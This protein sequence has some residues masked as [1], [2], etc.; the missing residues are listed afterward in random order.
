MAL[1]IL[2]PVVFDLR[3]NLTGRARNAKASF[4]KHDVVGGAPIYEATGEDEATATLECVLHPYHLGGLGRLEALYLAMQS[5]VPLSL[6][7]GDGVPLGWHV[8][9]EIDE[10]HAE[11]SIAGVGQEISFTLKLTCVDTPAMSMVTSIVSLLL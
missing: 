8:V 7:R 6:M 9:N 10:E 1:M 3:N 11:I 2:G 4:A 5:Q